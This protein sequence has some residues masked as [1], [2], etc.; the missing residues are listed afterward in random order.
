MNFRDIKGKGHNQ[1]RR[2][3]G[4]PYP[5][6][7]SSGATVCR[8]FC[9][10]SL[11]TQW[12]KP[13]GNRSQITDNLVTACDG[14]DLVSSTRTNMTCRLEVQRA[15]WLTDFLGTIF[16][17]FQNVWIIFLDIMTTSAL[18]F[19]VRGI[20]RIHHHWPSIFSR[21]IC[22]STSS[23]TES[24]RSCQ[25]PRQQSVSERALGFMHGSL[26]LIVVIKKTST[27]LRHY[28]STQKN[29]A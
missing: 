14:L 25:F 7:L 24:H 13:S 9:P 5:V 12:W 4:L 10:R 2:T 6:E 29:Y 20:Y 18:Q 8:P 16:A 22:K 26:N 11:E 3:P 27:L 1:R 17:P 21:W 19:Q 28:P 23:L 15:Q